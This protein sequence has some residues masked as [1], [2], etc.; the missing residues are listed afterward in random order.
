MLRSRHAL[1]AHDTVSRSRALFRESGTISMCSAS[2]CR[3]AVVSSETHVPSCAYL[4][5]GDV[6]AT[7]SAIVDISS[8]LH[9]DDASSTSCV[10]F[11]NSDMIAIHSVHGVVANDASSTGRA[12]FHDGNMISTFSADI[13]H[14]V[15]ATCETL[16]R[17]ENAIS[18]LHDDVVDD[19]IDV[20]SCTIQTH[21]C[22][23]S[24]KEANFKNWIRKLQREDHSLFSDSESFDAL[25]HRKE[26]RA[27][28]NSLSRRR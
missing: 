21:H 20:V 13:D 22:G 16:C 11:R 23:P 8:F 18:G 2:V 14:A 4:H 5:A 7:C 26:T 24:T 3:H 27:M 6:S 25:R 1:D 10:L 12:L 15:S 28:R 17:R 9:A 19:V